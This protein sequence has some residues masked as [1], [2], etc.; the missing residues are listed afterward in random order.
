M[1][2]QHTLFVIHQNK[3]I[4]CWRLPSKQASGLN[5]AH[6]YSKFTISETQELIGSS[7]VMSFFILEDQT[8]GSVC[9]RSRGDDSEANIRP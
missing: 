5:S 4:C 8:W 2:S 7:D 9:K 1:R 6:S 3:H